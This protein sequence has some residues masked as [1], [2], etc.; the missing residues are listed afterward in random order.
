MWARTGPR[1][2]P[3]RLTWVRVNVRFVMAILT[4]GYAE[5]GV[6]YA[7]TSVLH[8]SELKPERERARDMLPG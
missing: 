4:W 5:K 3:C 1:C 7:Q 2:P 8:E 6:S